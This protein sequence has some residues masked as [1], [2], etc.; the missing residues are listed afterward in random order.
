MIL[1]NIGNTN[2]T[3]LEDGKISRMKIS[4][5]K[6]FKPEKK[7]YF[8]SVNDEILNLLNEKSDIYLVSV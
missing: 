8:I 4:E 1:C 6:N 3:F 7:V 5:F 2:A